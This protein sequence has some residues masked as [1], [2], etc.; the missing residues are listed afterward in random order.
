MDKITI[1]ESTSYNGEGLFSPDVVNGKSLI[2]KMEDI[3]VS[4]F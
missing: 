4:E 2:A 1:I 3:D